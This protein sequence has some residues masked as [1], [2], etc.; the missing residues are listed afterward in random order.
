MQTITNPVEFEVLA[1]LHAAYPMAELH[2][3]DSEGF[4]VNP[5]FSMWDKLEAYTPLVNSS[6]VVVAIIATV[7]SII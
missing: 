1:D 2:V 7:E 3:Y 5:V 6:G 4:A